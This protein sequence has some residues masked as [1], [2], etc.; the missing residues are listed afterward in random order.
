MEPSSDR[1]CSIQIARLIIVSLIAVSA[2]SKTV[3]DCVLSVVNIVLVLEEIEVL[4]LRLFEREPRGSQI[5]LL[6]RSSNALLS[7]D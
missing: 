2:S 4:L 1:A 3:V 5:A 6:L 7:L